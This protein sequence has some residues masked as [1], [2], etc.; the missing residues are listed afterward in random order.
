M[1]VARS[2][3]IYVSVIVCDVGPRDGLQNEDKVLEPPVRAE[4]CD[5]L[6]AAGLRRTG[7]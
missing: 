7:M 4:L 5:R 1:P 6:S 3:F 2:T